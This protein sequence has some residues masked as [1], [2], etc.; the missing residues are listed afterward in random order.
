MTPALGCDR[1]CS[2]A[3]QSNPT[4][5]VTSWQKYTLTYGWRL[6]GFVSVNAYDDA[7]KSS[8]HFHRVLQRLQRQ[9]RACFELKGLMTRARPAHSAFV[10]VGGMHVTAEEIWIGN[11]GPSSVALAAGGRRSCRRE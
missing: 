7:L 2:S 3:E 5:N 10:D 1:V 11:A 4:W 9:P 6:D 8:F